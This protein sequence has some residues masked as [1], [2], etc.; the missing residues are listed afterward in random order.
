MSIDIATLFGHSTQQTRP[1]ARRLLD[2]RFRVHDIPGKSLD[3]FC[4]PFS[5]RFQTGKYGRRDSMKSVVVY[6]VS[7]VLKTWNFNIKFA[8]YVCIVNRTEW[9]S[10]NR[11]STWEKDTANEIK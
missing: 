6:M 11:L 1:H 5:Q 9:N 2:V 4:F 10:D 8:K 7:C 3:H